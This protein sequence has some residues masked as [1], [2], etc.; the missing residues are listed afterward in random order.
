MS[1][2]ASKYVYVSSELCG[3]KQMT[4]R[5][6]EACLS[7]A[8][9]L[10]VHN[11]YNEAGPFLINCNALNC[12]CTVNTLELGDKDLVEQLVHTK[13]Q[14]SSITNKQLNHSGSTIVYYKW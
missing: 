1:E 3:T 5:D 2:Y 4:V 6:L 12:V 10:P 13:L 7:T 14:Y 11:K 8:V 9:F